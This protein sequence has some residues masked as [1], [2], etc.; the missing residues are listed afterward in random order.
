MKGCL[1]EGMPL[2]AHCLKY[3]NQIDFIPWINKKLWRK[4]NPQREHLHTQW[5]AHN[6]I[7]EFSTS[8]YEMAKTTLY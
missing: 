4:R 1:L 6:F 5:K 2:Q 8:A 7:L 3:Q